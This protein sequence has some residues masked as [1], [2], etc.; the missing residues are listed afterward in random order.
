MTA[1]TSRLEDF[2][3]FDPELIVAPY[4]YY[5]RLRAEAP[6]Y[7]DSRSGI[8]QVASYEH[9]AEALK[10]PEIF[11]NRFGVAMGGSSRGLPS[12]VQE[13][14][15]D[16]WPPVDTMLTADPPEQKRFRS[17]VNRA[18]TPRRVNGLASAIEGLC[19]ELIDDFI[20]DG[21]VEVRSHYG[22]PVPLTVIA[23]QLGV[24]RE[25][26]A[27]FKR[28]SDGFVAQLGGMASLDEQVE[29]ARLI[30]EFQKYFASILE[31]RKQNPRDDILSDVVNAEVEGE[32]SLDTAECLSILQQLLVAGNET[33]ASSI[34]EGVLLLSQHPEARDQLARQPDLIPNF[35]EEVLR[36]ATPT[37]NMWRV[38]KCDTRLGGVD[39]PAG[40]MAMLRFA[41][42][43]RD[44][45]V[46][47]DPDR[48]DITRENA[49]DHV[50]FGLGIHFC[51][52]AMLAR[53]E[54]Q[55]AFER[56]LARIGNFR[57]STQ[58]SELI[59]EPN[60]LLRGLMEL[61]I[62]FDTP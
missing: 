35:V 51:L 59:Y 38:V 30:V 56:L 62:D 39:I 24:P 45:A 61:H 37:A 49:S 55:V 46:F 6:V 22:V 47:R 31:D 48:F 57:L 33:T 44:E 26:L 13:I 12:E 43:N 32:R 18:F 15:K 2:N 3:P 34:T 23:G 27:S 25:D 16:G 4:E 11:S 28:W 50:A 5:A 19:D 14:A 8:Y 9:V 42:A 60:I 53:K 1:P 10:K 54:M 17:L 7:L 58:Q 29:A 20:D 36:L 21:T 40:S 52:G 41:S